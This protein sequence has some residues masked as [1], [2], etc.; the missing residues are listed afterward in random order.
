[1]DSGMESPPPTADASSPP[2]ERKST[3]RRK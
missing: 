3:F 1:M 2:A